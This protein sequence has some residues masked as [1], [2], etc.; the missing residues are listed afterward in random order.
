MAFLM[1]IWCKFCG[2]TFG[3]YI[4]GDGKTK[5][6]LKQNKDEHEK[7]WCPRRFEEP[8]YRNSVE[9]AIDMIVE[10]RKR[11]NE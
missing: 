9:K 1:E 7:N 2:K 6:V 4:E 5:K 8:K 10:G 11:K 3:R